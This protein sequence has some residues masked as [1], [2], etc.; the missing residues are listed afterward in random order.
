MLENCPDGHGGFNAF[1][2]I[3][4]A[5]TFSRWEKESTGTRLAKL[6]LPAGGVRLA[7]GLCIGGGGMRRW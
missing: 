3:R 7:K 1:S 4:P 5:A 2:L 6:P